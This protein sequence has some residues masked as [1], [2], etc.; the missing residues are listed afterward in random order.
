MKDRNYAYEG[1]DI[2]VRARNS[3]Q[4]GGSRLV[5]AGGGGGGGTSFI[6]IHSSCSF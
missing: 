4:G 3:F 5:S 2:G 6:G 1:I